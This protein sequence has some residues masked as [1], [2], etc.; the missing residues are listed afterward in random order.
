MSRRCVKLDSINNNNNDNE[1]II[2]VI[3]IINSSS[4]LLFTDLVMQANNDGES[5]AGDEWI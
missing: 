3:I 2:V 1:I 4:N 5:V